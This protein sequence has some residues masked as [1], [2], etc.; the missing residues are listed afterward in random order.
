MEWVDIADTCINSEIDVFFTATTFVKQFIFTDVEM[1]P[2]SS[3]TCLIHCCH[4]KHIRFIRASE[5]LWAA[6]EQ[7][8]SPQSYFYLLYCNPLSTASNQIDECSQLEN[9]HSR[10]SNL[11]RELTY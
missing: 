7:K 2:N 11:L 5:A 1:P 3:P 10:L 4:Y 8:S 9:I 6:K